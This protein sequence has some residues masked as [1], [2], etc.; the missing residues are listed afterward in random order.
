MTSFQL[1][2]IA[3]G[4]PGRLCVRGYTETSSHTL[5]D[6]TKVFQQSRLAPAC[7]EVQLLEP[8]WGGSQPGD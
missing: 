2:L 4:S 6:K 1:S 3:A 5:P 7:H 8:T